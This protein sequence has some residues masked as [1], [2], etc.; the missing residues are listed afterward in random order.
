MN[1]MASVTGLTIEDFEKLPDALALNHE[2]V[3]GELV[4]VL[5]KAVRPRPGH[6]DCFTKRQI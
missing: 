4:D 6:R 3:D 2:L 5:G 1:L